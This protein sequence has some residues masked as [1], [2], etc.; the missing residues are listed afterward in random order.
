[1]VYKKFIR[2]N[3]KSYGPYY[4][5]SYRDENGNVVNRYVSKPEG[6]DKAGA[7]VEGC[8]VNGDAIAKEGSKLDGAHAESAVADSGEESKITEEAAAEDTSEQDGEDSGEEPEFEV[9]HREKSKVIPSGGGG[10]DKEVVDKITQQIT[11]VPSPARVRAEPERREMVAGLLERFGKWWLILP[12]AVVVIL[13]VLGIPMFHTTGNVSMEV[14]ENY[15]PGENLEGKIIFTLGEKELI[16]AD[17]KVFVSLGFVSRVFVLSD[18]V[19]AERSTGS[20]HVEGKQLEGSGE[21]FGNMVLGID[22]SRFN[23]TAEEGTLSVRLVYGDAEI[24]SVDKAISMTLD[25]DVSKASSQFQAMMVPNGTGYYLIKNAMCWGKGSTP[26]DCTSGVNVSDNIRYQVTAD[27]ANSAY[28]NGSWRINLS[29]STVKGVN[30]LIEWQS[31]DE[32]II[33]EWYFKNSSGGYQLAPCANITNTVKNIDLN[34]SCNLISA[35]GTAQSLGSVDLKMR[36]YRYGGGQN[37]KIDYF[38]LNVSYENRTGNQSIS[39]DRALYSLDST[40][41]VS[42]LGWGSGTNVTVDILFNGSSITGYPASVL[43]NS[44]GYVYNGFA[45]PLAAK[46][47][48]YEI[49]AYKTADK[50]AN[51]T[52]GF[53]VDW[54]YYYANNTLVI[55]MDWK[56]STNADNVSFLR[57]YGMMDRLI[58][59]GYPVDFVVSPKCAHFNA[60]NIDN[61]VSYDDDYC[62]GSI[63]IPDPNMSTSAN[64]ALGYINNTLRTIYDSGKKIYPFKD[65]IIHRGSGYIRGDDRIHLRSTLKLALFDPDNKDNFKSTLDESYL[66]YTELTAAQVLNNTLLK[67]NF[68]FMDMDEHDFTTAGGAAL[69]AAIKNFTDHGGS[70]SAECKSTVT[71]DPYTQYFPNITDGPALMGLLRV[72]TLDDPITQSH[73]LTNMPNEGGSHPT[74]DMKNVKVNYTIYLVDDNF[75][76]NKNITKMVGRKLINNS[77]VLYAGGHIGTRKGDALETARNR[78]AV[79]NFFVAVSE[80]MTPPATVKGLNEIAKGTNWIMWNWTNPIDSNFNHVEVWVN[81][82][83]YANVSSPSHTINVTGLSSGTAYNIGMITVSSDGMVNGTWVNDSAVTE[84]LPGGG[85]EIIIN[86]PTNAT[87]NNRTIF[88]NV[89]AEGASS[90]WFWNGT[91]NTTYTSPVYVTFPEGSVSLVVY[92]ND[93]MGNVNSTSVSFFVDSTPPV[94][95]GVTTYPPLPVENNGDSQTIIVNFSSEYPV[96]VTFNIYSS[97]GGVVLNQTTI[98]SNSSQLPLNVTIPDSLPDGTYTLNLTAMDGV[99]NPTI[100]NLGMIIVDSVA[101]QAV[102]LTPSNNTVTN[103][104]VQNFTAN[105]SDSQGVRN[106][107][108]SIYNTTGVYN[109][110][111]FNLEGEP[112]EI[113]SVAVT[114]VTGVYSWFWQVF[115]LANNLFSGGSSTITVDMVKPVIVVYSPGGNYNNATILINLTASGASSIWFWNG[116]ANV[117]Y[118]GPTYLTFGE[119]SNTLVIYANDSAGNVNSTSVTLFVDT[120][121]PYVSLISPHAGLYNV[122]SVLIE[123]N[124]S[125]ADL[126]WWGNATA[127]FSYLAPTIYSFTNGTH[128]IYAYA[129]D[130]AGNVNA[131][132]VTFAVNTTATDLNPPKFNT[133][134]TLPQPGSQYNQ[135]NPVLIAVHVGENAS[136]FANVSWD[137]TSEIVNLAYNGTEWFYSALFTN[138]SY[139]GAY[140]VVVTA[141]DSYGNSNTTMTNFTVVNLTAGDLTPP[142]IFG[143]GIEPYDP[144][145]G[146]SV[147][148]SAN[149]SDNLGVSGIFANITLPNGSAVTI[150][151]PADYVI[152]IAGR[153]NVTFFA[154]DSSGN[155]AVFEDY[156]IAG[157]SSLNITFNAVNYL[158]AG[159]PINLTIYFAGTEKEIHGHEFVGTFMDRHT[160][161]LYDLLFVSDFGMRVRLNSV[162]LSRYT[163]GTLGMDKNSAISANLTYGI[164]TTYGFSNANVLLSYAGAGYTNESAM[165]I[166]KCDNWDFTGRVCLGAWNDIT[167]TSEKNAVEDN[168]AFNVTSFSGFGIREPNIAVVPSGGGGGG[169][170]GGGAVANYTIALSSDLIEASLIQ[171][172]STTES[173]RLTNTGITSAE[174][175]ARIEGLEGIAILSESNFTIGSRMWETLN[176][177]FNASENLKPEVYVGKIII[178]SKYGTKSVNLVLTVKQKISVEY[179]LKA[180]FDMVIS[181]SNESESA[182]AGGTVEYNVVLRNLGEAGLVTAKLDVSVADLEKKDLFAVRSGEVALGGGQGTTRIVGEFK[183][184]RGF[185]AGRYMV[186]GKLSYDNSSAEAYDLFEVKEAQGAVSGGMKIFDWLFALLVLIE[187]ILL[188]MILLRGRGHPHRQL[189]RTRVAKEKIMEEEK[190]VMEELRRIMADFRKRKFGKKEFLARKKEAV[191]KLGEFE[192][193]LKQ[194]KADFDR[195]AEQELKILGVGKAKLK[196]KL[197]KLYSEF[198]ERAIDKKGYDSAKKKLLG[199]LHELERHFEH[200]ALGK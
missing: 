156:F 106:A 117:A 146:E 151:A 88:V 22:V 85:F 19:S 161:I 61:G 131:T 109:Q 180:L 194:V 182:Y 55:P 196:E 162:N 35:F 103:R 21:G 174:V 166:E 2:R 167:S 71:L 73:N 187:L 148:L 23:L 16:P 65:V 177:I 67:E 181:V 158:L 77:Y 119:G 6:E 41:F 52:D 127:N 107:T 173:L 198:R 199:E 137:S 122:S 45:I 94:V 76:T 24:A 139:A 195:Y 62:H 115:D 86:S 34:F 66:N 20:Y 97:T 75:N 128:T 33:G 155:I 53:E 140:T 38:A 113:V 136:V 31:G 79:N 178:T 193:E 17:S 46:V 116:T 82:A 7:A 130:S 57:A 56:Q 47:G 51:I 101:P 179:P 42:G 144:A 126:I 172:N 189:H 28:I 96:S 123:I 40:G 12:M 13:L 81:G 89:T 138:T 134:N 112:G 190:R 192:G 184:P 169:G 176:V 30:A 32:D 108:L 11:G 197:G 60:V 163:N 160:D 125:G 1:M 191:K 83:F 3:G 168:F 70:L 54:L 8:K 93:S 159:I 87:Y 157:H 118:I 90:I 104:S 152:P 135:T 145:I 44:S 154:N 183:V 153:Y 78:I 147:H 5:E 15:A 50:L 64:E 110:S 18:V 72:Y 80:A 120:I 164:N 170:G 9:W 63:I 185:A 14:K 105:I 165:T 49:F 171:G 74:L 142:S 92:A 25:G 102:A 200:Y 175:N 129:R 111:F 58:D 149:A 68:N 48:N 124:S 100:I 114:L 27:S 84:Y 10:S 43:A 36:F 37:I 99:G 91:A 26:T 29:S 98:V 121:L 95:S 141:V 186:L 188:I 59:N 133:A 39:S 143:T 4:Y 69:A 150:A 132:S